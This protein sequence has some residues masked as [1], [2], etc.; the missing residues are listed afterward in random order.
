MSVLLLLAAAS[1]AQEPCDLSSGIAGL[2]LV[3]LSS[4]H[5][6]PLGRFAVML[7][8]DG[9]WRRIDARVTDRFRDSGVPVVGLRTNEYF[10]IRRTPEESACALERTIRFYQTKWKRPRVMVIGYSRGADVLPFMLSR[11]PP[12]LRDAIDVVAL[13]GLEPTIDFKYHASWVPGYHPKEPQFD[14]APEVEKL[15]GLRILCVYGEK[16]KNSLCRSLDPTLATVVRE[17]GSHHFAGKYT[18]IADEILAAVP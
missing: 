9:G 14:V 17:P 4:K 5:P 11:L 15:R 1:F 3:E 7:T 10:R 2:P 8:G 18:N 6:A 16:E 13:L 12:D